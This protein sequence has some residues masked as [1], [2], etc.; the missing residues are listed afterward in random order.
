M[1]NTKKEIFDALQNMDSIRQERN[2]LAYIALFLF[3]TTCLF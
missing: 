3:A 1:K 2:L